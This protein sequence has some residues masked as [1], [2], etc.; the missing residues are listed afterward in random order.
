MTGS[1]EVVGSIPIS[2]TRNTNDKSKLENV[3]FALFSFDGFVTVESLPPFKPFR[4]IKNKIDCES[5]AMGFYLRF[6]SFFLPT[7]TAIRHKTH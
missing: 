6:P 3:W 5:C 4:N 7:S 1:H 2:S